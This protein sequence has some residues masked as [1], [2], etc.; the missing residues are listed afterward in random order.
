[1][2]TTGRHE[3]NSP[4]GRKRPTGHNGPK[5]KNENTLSS[6]GNQAIDAKSCPFPMNYQNLINSVT[7]NMS[8]PYFPQNF[9]PFHSIALPNFQRSCVSSFYPGHPGF[10]QNHRDPFRNLD[11]NN[12]SRSIG[13]CSKSFSSSQRRG[14][15]QIKPNTRSRETPE[16]HSN[17]YLRYYDSRLRQND[18]KHHRSQNDKEKYHKGRLPTTQFN[19][20]SK[21]RD[22]RETRDKYSEKHSFRRFNS[23]SSKAEAIHNQGSSG[24]RSVEKT[25]KIYFSGHRRS[26]ASYNREPQMHKTTEKRRFLLS[27]KHRQRHFADRKTDLRSH[28]RQIRSDALKNEEFKYRHRSDK[29]KNISKS[30]YRSPRRRQSSSTVRRYKDEKRSTKLLLK[31]LEQS[32]TSISCDD[33]GQYD[34]DPVLIVD[35]DGDCIE[36]PRSENEKPDFDNEKSSEFEESIASL[37]LEITDATSPSPLDHEAEETQCPS[38]VMQS[39]ADEPGDCEDQNSGFSETSCLTPTD[40]EV[41]NAQYDNKKMSIQ[42][43]PDELLQVCQIDFSSLDS[44][45]TVRKRRSRSLSPNLLSEIECKR[46]RKLLKVTKLCLANK[47][48]PTLRQ[49]FFPTS[50]FAKL[51]KFDATEKCTPKRV[52]R[53]LSLSASRVMPHL[54]AFNMKKSRSLEVLS[55]KTNPDF[56]SNY[57]F[58]NV[59]LIT[60]S[61]RNYSNAKKNASHI[62]DIMTTDYQKDQIFENIGVAKNEKFKVLRSNIF[63][64]CTKN[65][66]KF[67]SFP[68]LCS[69]LVSLG[70]NA[71]SAETA[72]VHLRRSNSLPLVCGNNEK[73]N[74]QSAELPINETSVQEF[75]SLQSAFSDG[76]KNRSSRPAELSKAAAPLRRSNT[77]SLF[78]T[79]SQT[80]GVSSVNASLSKH[81]TKSLPRS[82]SL[83]LVSCE[84]SNVF[85]HPLETITTN[86][87]LPGCCSLSISNPCNTDIS[88]RSSIDKHDF[89]CTLDSELLSETDLYENDLRTYRRCHSLPPQAHTAS[90][91]SSAKFIPSFTKFTATA[92]KTVEV[93]DKKAQ[94]VSKS[95]N[96]SLEQGFYSDDFQK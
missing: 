41:Y 50:E 11:E 1:M 89:D 49:R 35:P 82:N 25:T 47:N 17:K 71:L 70:S 19:M 84:D 67:N 7:L 59:P 58:K 22:N 93:L 87:P 48:L 34:Y 96:S 38:L 60:N 44:G 66:R 57:S 72:S 10:V 52:L 42:D 74:A 73:F 20:I 79:K 33:L 64:C 56:D 86:T 21:S 15:Q 3:N 63:F 80:A 51:R 18:S 37:K 36:I 77:L 28:L 26:S 90:A 65:L 40:P 4:I 76:L 23:I 5:V 88:A 46:R 83:S 16:R 12:D 2:K 29:S 68:S 32:G 39:V 24:S 62:A 61:D 6:S 55:L 27:S 92:D 54:V 14:S 13:T 75:S 94:V 81:Q 53:S 9:I 85:A 30:R 31:R 95:V 45:I 78:W 8:Q 43:D 69:K 91:L